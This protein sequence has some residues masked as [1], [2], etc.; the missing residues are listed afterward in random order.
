MNW[1]LPNLTFPKSTQATY[2]I[3]LYASWTDASWWRFHYLQSFNVMLEKVMATHSST[4]A[5]K[6]PL[7]EEPG[8]LHFM[9]SRRAGRDWVTSLS[10]S[11][12]GEGTGN[13]LQCSCLE[14]P[15]GG[16]AWWAA[17]DGVAQSR[18]RLKRVSSSSSNVILVVQNLL[19]LLKV[20]PKRVDIAQLSKIY[21]LSLNNQYDILQMS[22]SQE[23]QS[24]E[25]LSRTNILNFLKTLKAK[26]IKMST[27]LV[28]FVKLSPSTFL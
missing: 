3:K 14:N 17:V 6:I 23:T 2:F 10:L 12:I 19:M 28:R 5:W 11:R 15:R 25:N 16:G 20:F 26:R 22:K 1:L 7:A 8:R 9:G 13:P 18:T 4:L 24:P 21:P 27:L